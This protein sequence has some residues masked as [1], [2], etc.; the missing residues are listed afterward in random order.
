M[1]ASRIEK[2]RAVYDEFPRQFW[3]LLSVVFIDMVG[4]A[5]VFPFFALFITDKFDVGMAQVGII[6]TILSLTG[7]VGGTIG[8]ALTDKIGR[9]PIILLSLLVSATANVFLVLIP[10]FELMYVLAFCLGLVGSI[11]GPAWQAMVADLLPEE[12]RAEGFGIIRVVFNLAV[13]FGPMI[14]GLLAGISYV[15]L[16]A[17]DAATSLI[18]ALILYLT[19]AE[20]KPAATEDTPDESLAQT[21][22]GYGTV[23]RDRVFILF[24]L[25]GMVVVMVYTQ[26][27][28]TLAVFLRD[29]HD[30]PPQGFGMLIGL[31]ALMVVV[32]QFWITRQVKQR[33]YPSMLVLAG[34]TLLYAIG[35][36]LFGFVSTMTFFVLAMVIVTI[37]EMLTAPVG[38]ALAA[39][40]ARADMRGRYMAVFGFGFSLANGGG[41]FV[42]GMIMDHIDP[43][44]VWFAAGIAGTLAAGAYVALHRR[45]GDPG[46]DAPA[47]P[48][49]IGPLPE[50]EPASA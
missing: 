6:F 41:I 25:V 17:I 10:T 5:L 3:L 11:G 18:T 31:N 30:I 1:F 8:G 15:L 13:T 50:G 26:M 27:N 38:Q 9:R 47:T 34:G 14:G 12:K 20:T 22:R 39:K 37:G 4:N 32:L 2:L 42:A 24:T 44:W 28:S 23:L 45:V 40:F 21:F 16:F 48:D 33:G 19:L 46:A 7:I 49:R 43:N 36:A 35:F 29:V